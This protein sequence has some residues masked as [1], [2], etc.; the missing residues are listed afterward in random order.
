MKLELTIKTSYLPSWGAYEGIREL[1]QNGKDA[2]TEFGATFEV[3]YRKDTGV[4]VIENDGTTL[5]HEALL[6]GHTSKSDRGD[7][8]GKFGEGLKLGVLALVRAGHA[9]KIRSGSEVWTP[10]IERSEKFHADV[11]VFN[12]DKGREPKNRVQVEIGN[13]AEESWTA[14]S[15]LFLFLGKLPKDTTIKTT[16]GTLLLDP[17]YKG[18]VYVKGIFVQNVG[19]LTFGYDLPDADV[20]RDRKMIETWS[21]QSRSQGIWRAALATRPDLIQ[22]FIELLESEAADVEG[23]NEWNASDLSEEVKVGVAAHFTARHGDKAIPV[24]T[25][26][27]SK[28]VEHLGKTGIVCPKP[29]RNIL[30]EKLGTVAAN[31]VKL[32]KECVKTFGWHELSTDEKANLERAIAL[33]NG[34]TPTTLDDVDIIECRDPKILGLFSNGRVQLVKRILT[35]R[36]ETLETLVHEVAHK[37]GGGDGE[38]GHVANIEKLWSGIVANLTGKAS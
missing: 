9:V 31:K 6:F 25:L 5:P 18:R 26:S 20:D 19:D 2:Q 8:I 16:S 17:K 24:S 12:I 22:N 33:V 32:A 15:D 30:E 29:L 10:S 11:L 1:I 28:E 37:L 7:L 35:D 34:V 3:R 36:D 14:M 27:D 4:L 21:L 23:I 38:H 13:I